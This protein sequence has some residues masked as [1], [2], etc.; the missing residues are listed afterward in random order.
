MQS[1]ALIRGGDD[2]EDIITDFPMQPFNHEQQFAH[3]PVKTLCCSNAQT[4]PFQRVIIGAFTGN[5]HALLIDEKGG[6]IVSTTQ[7]NTA[8]IHK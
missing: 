1:M 2:E 7:Y 4:K 3:L 6:H 8:I 5:R